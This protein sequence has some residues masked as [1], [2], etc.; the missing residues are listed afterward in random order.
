MKFNKVGQVSLFSGVALILATAFTACSP[1]TIDYLYVAGSKATPGQIQTFEVD[2]VTGALST[3]GSTLTDSIVSSGGTNPISAVPAP[4][5]KSLYVANQGSSNLVQFTIAGSGLPSSPTTVA[6]SSEGNTPV[7]IAINSNGTL[8]YVINQFQPGCSTATTG[9]STCSGGALAVF[10]LGSNGGIGSPVANGK[11]NYWPVGV[12]PTA[13]NALTNGADVFVTT[14]DPIAGNG[15]IYSFGVNGSGALTTIANS[16]YFAGIKPMG[17]ASDPTNR[18][19]YVT[20]F[21]QNEL[22]AY[23]VISGGILR[24]L[25]N[26]PFKTGNEPSAIVID[27]RGKFLYLTNELDN[28]VS[29][30]DIDLPTGT[31][32]AAVNVTGTATN[33]TGTLP[34]AIVV[35]AGFGRYVFTANFIDDSASGFQLNP[36]TG[37]LA[38]AQGGPFPSVGQP[39]ALASIPRGNH[40][41]QTIQP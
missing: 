6:L 21:S 22:I 41:I 32:S 10:P 12:N 11:L 39:T 17:I 28:T 13:V 29:A 30:Y 24:P 25:I 33:N 36:S 40:S 26:G 35:D 7:A 1:V 5:G 8:L 38:P 27:P 37:T 4:N 18:Y 9:A 23:S 34:V 3:V 14:Y 20:D 2:R 16:P 19:V 31:P 15:Y